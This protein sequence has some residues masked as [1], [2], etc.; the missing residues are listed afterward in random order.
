MRHNGKPQGGWDLPAAS[1]GLGLLVK[2]CMSPASHLSSSSLSLSVSSSISSSWTLALMAVS[3]LEKASQETRA[4]CHSSRIRHREPDWWCTRGKTQIK[5]G[6][7]IMGEGCSKK[8]IAVVLR[9]QSNLSLTG[10][11]EMI[12]VKLYSSV[13]MCSKIV[14]HWRLS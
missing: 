11:F 8:V 7:K 3:S 13:L 10:D 2:S 14:M 12:K 5:E 1:P 4:H 6:M 9:Y